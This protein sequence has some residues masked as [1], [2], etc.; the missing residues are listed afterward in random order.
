VRSGEIALSAVLKV[1]INTGFNL[2]IPNVPSILSEFLPSAGIAA[3]MFANIAEFTTNVKTEDE[4]EDE[5]G[6]LFGVEQDFRFA[7]GA[8][9]GATI[10]LRDETW[11]PSPNT[12]IDLW[13]TRIADICGKSAPVSAIATTTTLDKRQDL[14]TATLKSTLQYTGVVCMSSMAECPASLQ[15]HTIATSVTTLTS[16]LPSGETPAW[17]ATAADVVPARVKFGSQA[18]AL[19]SAKGT[20]T[21]GMGND[22]EDS[23][24]DKAVD[25]VRGADK[26]LIIGL[27]VG[28]GGAALVA[29]GAAVFF[30]VRK[31]NTHQA[32]PS[33]KEPMVMTSEVDPAYYGARYGSGGYGAPMPSPAP[34][35]PGKTQPGVSYVA[36]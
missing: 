13:S 23:I 19:F 15:K 34:G 3:S 18:K 36:R 2:A 30:C 33:T 28:L 26:R 27:S 6:C 16:I 14:S 17:P 29:L 11:G 20:P 21:P 12:T 24:L 1:S 10:K 4:D 8:A 32:V 9:A 31:R 7:I 35:S 22:N 25:V 5:D